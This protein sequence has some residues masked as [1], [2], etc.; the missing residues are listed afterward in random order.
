MTSPSSAAPRPDPAPASTRRHAL[1][2]AAA[3]AAAQESEHLRARVAGLALEDKVRLLTGATAWRLHAAPEAGLRA[4]VLSDGPAGVRGTGEDPGETS[5]SFPA[6]SALAATWDL[7]LAA[8]AGRMLAV[9]ARRH[10]ADV[11]LA[12]VVNL[13]RTPVGGRH[14]ECFSEDP[15]L[16]GRI[17]AEVIASLQADGIGACVKH[18]VANDSE[19]ARTSSVAQVSERALREVY[20]APFE[21]AV[22][23]ARA[24]MVMAAHNGVDDGAQ[25][26]PMTEHR[27]LLR[28]VLK[29]EWGF[30]GVVV[31]DRLAARTT[32]PTANAGL[33]LV[34]P[35]P[36]G[37]WEDHLLAAVRVGEVAEAEIDDKVLRILR[38]AARVGALAEPTPREPTVAEATPADDAARPAVR[39]SPSGHGPGPVRAYLRELAARAVVVLRDSPRQVPVDPARLLSVALIG[40]NAADPHTQGGGSAHVTPDRVV[41]PAEGLRAALPGAHVGVHRGGYARRNPPDLDVERL[42]SDPVTGRRGVRVEVLAADGAVLESRVEAARWTGWVRTTHPGA[43]AV[44]VAADVTLF[45]PGEHWVGVGT[46]GRHEIRIEGSVVSSDSDEIGADVL[47]DGGLGSPAAVGR[48]AIVLAPRSVRVEAR[49]QLVAAEG[50]G[51]V[52]R[53]ALR[54]RPP[55][56]TLEEEIAAA[57]A[58]AEAADLAVVIVGTNEEVES[59]GF[60]RTALSLPGRQDE[61]VE[62]VLAA[63][64]DAVVVVNA[65]APVLLPWLPRARTVLWG[66]LGG[67][68]WGHALADVLLGRTE[69][70]GR[71]P[72]TLPA[73]L[74]DVPVPMAIPGHDGVIAYLE[75]LHVGYRSWE[76]SGRT[77]AAP[78]GHGLGWTDWAYDGLAGEESDDGA[79]ALSVRVRNVGPRFGREVVQAYLEAA[80]AGS[81]ES[82][83]AGPERPVRWLAGFAV[84]AAEPGAAVHATIVVPRRAFEVWDVDAQTWVVPPGHY[85]IRV[86]RSVRDLRLAVDV[87][88]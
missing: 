12:P 26:A 59:E 30:D 28:D 49:L 7:A 53:A 21:T 75:G 71:L 67:Q 74:F 43:V 2:A 73:S 33:D 57:V 41:T 72:W 13:Q 22:R 11:V 14:F 54:H 31:S 84:V 86:G 15:L 52:A 20:L 66:W 77:P 35:G 65:G 55:G 5:A 85:R 9:E 88:R 25:A 68:E 69:P 24:W 4:V 48:S 47:L 87:H 6:P 29:D 80:D 17:A 44:R 46:L 56:P 61:L 79:L 62:R 8:R 40:P 37:P 60:D 81:D 27:H 70:A 32:V 51:R 3:D 58:A 38:L 18:F 42:A 78:F 36:G 63:R 83:A 19:T 16:T 82:E 23:D 39:R 45:E 1:R 76:M 10:G 64:P 50:L 34:M